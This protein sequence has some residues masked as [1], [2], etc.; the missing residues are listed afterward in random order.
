MES[1]GRNYNY[2]RIIIRIN[3]NMFYQDTHRNLGACQTE[4]K[5]DL[6]MAIKPNKS[7]FLYVYIYPYYK[8]PVILS[9]HPLDLL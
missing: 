6:Q 8:F 3:T 2:Q 4:D 1:S 5:C 7:H 9:H